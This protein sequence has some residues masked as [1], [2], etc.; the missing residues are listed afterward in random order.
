VHADDVAEAYRL[1]ATDPE[2]RGAYNIA[3]EPLLDVPALARLLGA[4][5]VR[6]PVRLVRALAGLTWRA[7]LQPT[8]PGWLDMGLEVPAM[9][10][11]RAREAL[12]WE[13][14][15]DAGAAL[16]ELLDGLRRMQGGDS[17][18]LAAGAGGPARVRE[19]LSGVGRRN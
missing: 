8:P 7:R 6:V 11:S 2:A 17:P 10:T 12:G 1:A 9:D 18:P 16:L 5:P 14:R 3:A 13:P 4:R 15:R 19:V